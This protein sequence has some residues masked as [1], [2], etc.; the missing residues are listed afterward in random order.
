MDIIRK[1][2]TDIGT[3][4][5]G[6]NAQIDAL[7]EETGELKEMMMMKMMKMQAN[8]KISNMNTSR[9]QSNY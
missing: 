8:K 2:Q 1:N 5:R 3:V 9:Q 4:F 7:M 6:L